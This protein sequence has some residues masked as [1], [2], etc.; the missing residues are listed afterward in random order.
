MISRLLRRWFVY[1]HDEGEEQQLD[2]YRC[3]TCGRLITHRK[4]KTNNLCCK[5][6]VSP[7]NPSFFE[8]IRLFV[9]PWSI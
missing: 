9:F 2:L 4:I 5:S 6:R 7:T 3:L 1:F 8:I